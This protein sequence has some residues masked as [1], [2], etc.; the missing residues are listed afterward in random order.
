MGLITADA[1]KAF[2]SGT[3]TSGQAAVKMAPFLMWLGHGIDSPANDP[4]AQKRNEELLARFINTLR[5]HARRE[6]TR[7]TRVSFGRHA[8]TKP[9]A[10]SFH[11]LPASG[12]VFHGIDPSGIA[13][14][15]P[16]PQS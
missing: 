9:F 8:L 15:H 14:L 16:F 7:S 3:L 12:R 4:D 2:A 13:V 1:H 11:I 6:Q 10:R 5:A